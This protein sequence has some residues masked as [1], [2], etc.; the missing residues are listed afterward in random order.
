MGIEEATVLKIEC[1]KHGWQRA[2]VTFSGYCYCEDCLKE[3]A[4]KNVNNN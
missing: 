3:V 2:V 1:P 4:D